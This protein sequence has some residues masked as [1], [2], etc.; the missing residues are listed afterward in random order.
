MHYFSCEIDQNKHKTWSIHP[1][2]RVKSVTH[3]SRLVARG[4]SSRRASTWSSPARRKRWT[5]RCQSTAPAARSPAITSHQV[6][7]QPQCTHHH[8]QAKGKILLPSRMP[9]VLPPSGLSGRSLQFRSTGSLI[10]AIAVQRNIWGQRY[11]QGLKGMMCYSVDGFWYKR[12][13]LNHQPRLH[14]IEWC[15][16]SPSNGT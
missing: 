2:P 1:W 15:C 8:Q 14:H 16:Y 3:P 4:S 10:P 6:Q 7:S 13:H 5:R 9:Q 12:I 11:Q